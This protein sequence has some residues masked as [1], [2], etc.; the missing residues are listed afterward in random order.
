MNKRLNQAN[1]PK[2]N[3]LINVYYVMNDL[4]ADQVP[5]KRTVIDN[6]SFD[7]REY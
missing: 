7:C 6:F 3:Y 4:T 1:I 2:R 5:K